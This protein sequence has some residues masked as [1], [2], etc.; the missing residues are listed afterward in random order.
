MKAALVLAGVALLLAGCG[1][2]TDQSPEDSAAAPVA[3]TPEAAGR[4]SAYRD[5]VLT[6]VAGSYGGACHGIDGPMPAQGVTIDRD[7][8]VAAGAWHIDLAGARLNLARTRN[9]GAAAAGVFNASGD[10]GGQPYQLIITSDGGGSALFGS[11][12]KGTQCTSVAAASALAAKPLYPAVAQFFTSAGAS[13]T[14]VENGALRETTIKPEPAGLVLGEHRLAFDATA[15]Q[16]FISVEAQQGLLEYGARYADQSHVELGVDAAGKLVMA[17][18][19][20]KSG[21][22]ILC[23]PK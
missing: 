6:L 15:A 10:G 2:S 5:A 20:S 12:T 4:L 8:S 13:M 17:A 16:E 18:Y 3:A 14:C 23:S 9:A 7:G 21:A 11:G 19:T 1:K 22:A